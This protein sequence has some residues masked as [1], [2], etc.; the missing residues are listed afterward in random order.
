MPTNG[1]INNPVPDNSKGKFKE[2]KFFRNSD[3]PEHDIRR[4]TDGKKNFTIT[5][6]DIDKTILD[7]MN[8]VV[9][10][11]VVDVGNTVKV[12]VLYGNPERWKAIEIDGYLRDTT[13]KIQLPVI[14]F[15]RTSF[16]KN[17]SLMTLNRYL[18]YP[19][20]TKYSEKNRYDKFSVLEKSNA[21]VNQ[22]FAVALPDHVKIEYEFMVWTEYV[23]QMN[24]IIEKINF[25]VNDYWGDP[26]KFKFRVSVDDYSNTTEVVSDKDRMIRTTFNMTVYGY[27][28]PESYENRM[29]TT[30]KV[31]TYRKIKI[32]GE[33]SLQTNKLKQSISG[34]YYRVNNM[35][36]S[37]DDSW[38]GPGIDKIE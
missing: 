25:A 19:I 7:Y 37:G 2:N 21:P 17:E 16:T 18:T 30:N 5:L 27:L 36:S 1:N 29:K 6:A 3:N 14:M 23:E 26:L 11:S 20:L 32:V 13:G 10:P 9:S 22:I 34:S 31:L 35:I 12:P 38:Q 15:K 8:N 33:S 24:S 28:L 4:D